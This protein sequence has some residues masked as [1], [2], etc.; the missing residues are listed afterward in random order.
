MADKNLEN[1]QSGGNKELMV[2][3]TEKFA[4]IDQKFA[5]IDQRFDGIDQRFAAIDQKF[6][7][8][9]QKLDNFRVEFDQKLD[10]FRVQFDQKLDTFRVQFDQKLDAFQRQNVSDY[11]ELANLMAGQFEK[12]FETK[13]DKSDIDRV[14]ARVA[15]L[16]DKIDDYRAEQNGLSR[17]VER[18]EKWHHQ[19]AA[20]IGLKLQPE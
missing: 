6:I 14:L 15:L 16:G 17:Q 2:F 10:T 13:V 5:A 8:F 1:N 11:Q 7:A 4:A 9:D 18:H 3:L 20:K 19:T 12:V